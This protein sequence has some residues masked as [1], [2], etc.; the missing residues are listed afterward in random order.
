MKIPYSI[1]PGRHRALELLLSRHSPWPLA[2]PVPSNEELDVVFAAALRAADHGR[3]QPWRFALVRENALAALGDAYAEVALTMGRDIDP[4]R[5]RAKALA[6]PMVIAVAARLEAQ[7]KIPEHEQLLSAGAA[8]MNILNALH[9][10]G[11]GGFW[12]SP[13]GGPEGPLRSLMGFGP[14]ER[15]VA[16]IHVG[17]AKEE[18]HSPMRA[19][20]SG[21]VSEWQGAEAHVL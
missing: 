18:S 16:M 6:S 20:P 5:A 14:T 2:G 7:G 11:Y 17:T 19:D 12:K 15:I 13:P 3:L 4:E 1:N 9:M 21:F 8:T 10:M